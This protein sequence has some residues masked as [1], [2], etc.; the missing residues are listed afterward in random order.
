MGMG[1][2]DAVFSVPARVHAAYGARQVPYFIKR[3]ILRRDVQPER[4]Y[5]AHSAARGDSEGGKRV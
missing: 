1:N 2:R 3:Y 5:D 4:L